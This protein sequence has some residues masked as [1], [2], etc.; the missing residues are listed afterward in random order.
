MCATNNTC[1]RKEEMLKP[2]Q[3]AQHPGP[4]GNNT[5]V[6]MAVALLP[7]FFSYLLSCS[8]LCCCCHIY[9]FLFCTTRYNA[10]RRGPTRHTMSLR[11]VKFAGE[12]ICRYTLLQITHEKHES[13]TMQ[14]PKR[15]THRVYRRNAKARWL[16]QEIRVA[17]IP[18]R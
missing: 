7:F 15:I 2:Q 6:I 17:I 5:K 10:G 18:S 4:A 14:V 16:R 11:H 12:C 3:Q 13:Y 1:K 8:H 9:F